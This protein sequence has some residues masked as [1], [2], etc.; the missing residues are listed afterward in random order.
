KIFI[1]SFGENLIFKNNEDEI[2]EKILAL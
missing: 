2:A 1:D